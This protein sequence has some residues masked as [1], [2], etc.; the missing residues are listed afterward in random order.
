MIEFFQQFSPLMQVLFATLV[1]LG[2]YGGWCG[3]GF[4][5]E[6]GQSE[7]NGFHARLCRRRH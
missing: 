7:G 5:F 2:C 3:A 1:H 4:L 6:D